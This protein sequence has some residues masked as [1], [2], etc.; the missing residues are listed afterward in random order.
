MASTLT[1][2]STRES[3][4]PAGSRLRC[5]AQRSYGCGATTA[6]DGDVAVGAV[7]GEAAASGGAVDP[8]RR[9]PAADEVGAEG[10]LGKAAGRGA[11]LGADIRIAALV[12]TRSF[13][14]GWSALGG[15]RRRCRGAAVSVAGADVCRPRSARLLL[16]DCRADGAAAP[17]ER[18][19][20]CSAPRSQRCAVERVRGYL[21]LGRLILGIRSAAF[22]RSV[23]M[24]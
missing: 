16:R 10:V 7:C 15:R 2:R 5:I 9:C 3:H 6:G 22:C 4:L 20:R 11:T 8:Q 14:G 23:A 18:A 17:P 19:R 12:G 21:P 24:R 1:D 13:V